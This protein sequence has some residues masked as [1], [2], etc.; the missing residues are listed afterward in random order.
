MAYLTQPLDMKGLARGNLQQ[1]S[2]RFEYKFIS[3]WRPFYIVHQYYSAALAYQAISHLFWRGQWGVR[4][5]GVDRPPPDGG[6]ATPNC[7]QGGDCHLPKWR[8]VHSV[9]SY[10]SRQSVISGIDI[11]HSSSGRDF[12]GI[13]VL[14]RMGAYV[15][16][17]FEDAVGDAPILNS[18][19]SQHKEGSSRLVT[20]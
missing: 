2:R 18:A 15:M 16:A 10:P 9:G 19:S 3:I 14:V 17:F 1:Q 12:P 20:S 6:T 7:Q 8:A 11:G 13:E 5:A 4:I